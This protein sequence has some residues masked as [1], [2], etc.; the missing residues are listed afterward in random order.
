[1]ANMR[2]MELL[3]RSVE[4]AALDAALATV[5]A[6]GPAVVLVSGEAGIGKTSLLRA[7]VAEPSDTRLFAG[8][9]DAPV[10]AAAARPAARHRRG[11]GR[12][13]RDRSPPRARR[14]RA[15][16]AA[17]AR[18][19]RTGAAPRPRAR[20][21]ALGRRG[22]PRRRCACSRRRI[23]AV[24]ALVVATYRDD[25]LDR[26][27]PLRIAL[28]E[29]PQAPRTGCA[30]APLRAE[31]VAAL[32]E[33][34]GASIPA[35]STAS[36]GGQ[37]VL[38]H[39]GPRRRRTARAARR[40]SATR[41][42]RAPARLATAPARCS[43]RSRSCR[44]SAEL[45][46][47]EALAGGDL[48]RARRLPRA[49]AC[50]G[51]RGRRSR[52]ATRSRASRWRTRSPRTRGWPC[53]PRRSRRSPLRRRGR[54]D[55]ARLAHHAEAAGD[56]EAVLAYAPAAGEQAAALGAHREAA[57]QFARALRHAEALEPDRRAALLERV[58]YEYYLINC[59]RRGDRGPPGRARRALAAGDRCAQGRC[60]PLAV[61]AGR[62]SRATT[63]RPRSEA[64]HAIDLLEPLAPGP[65]LAMAYSNMAQLRMLASDR[66]GR[67]GLGRARD[68]AGRA[69]RRDGDPR[70]RAQQ[71]R[72][73]GDG[74]RAGEEG[75]R[76][77]SAASC[78]P[79]TRGSRSTSARAY[80][81]LAAH[82][83][84]RATTRARTAILDAG[85]AYCPERDLDSWQAVHERLPGAARV[86]QGR[87]DRRR[88]DRRRVLRTPN[89]R[90]RPDHAAGGPGAHPRA[91]RRARPVVAARRGARARRGDRRAAAARRRRHRAG[92][93]ALAGGR[94][95]PGR[96]PRRPRCSPS[97]SSRQHDAGWSASS[98]VVS[99]RRL[100][101]APRRRRARWPSRG[102]ELDGEYAKAA[103]ALERSSA[104]RTRSA[105][106]PPPRGRRGPLQRGLEELQRLGRA[107]RAGVRR[108]DAARATGSRRAAGP[109]RRD[110]REP[111]RHDRARARGARPGP[112]RGCATPRSPSG[113]FVSEKTVDH[114]VSAILRKLGGQ[115]AQRGSRRGGTGSGSSKDRESSR[116]GRAVAAYRVVSVTTT[117]EE[118]AWTC[119]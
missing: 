12:R 37:P 117:K 85:I 34:D 35:S 103:K 14:R 23:E 36:R 44:T 58:S 77:S 38:R 43:T 40:P 99:A 13:P 79:S 10:H 52:S 55:R 80:T 104:A 56:R 5:R 50:C 88:R 70:P 51:R 45:W 42:W 28:G 100:G 110:P 48:G 57:A 98:R 1:M 101:P 63:R 71:R 64:R 116:C 74:A 91:P 61:A 3:E 102:L 92:R 9:C 26:D 108:P 118:I 86:R 73:R 46:L 62:G 109:A 65:E 84:E 68:R 6:S 75:T 89:G 27:H 113:S 119:T 112:A 93:G 115:D 20:G 8:A 83:V 7:F 60:P 53:T 90:P 81:N 25:E 69:P 107:R 11:G 24:P 30:L 66:H 95:R 111:G 16:V 96:R 72:Q 31:A 105:L 17:L 59:D 18:E 94:V 67:D 39:R 33:P 106:A 29:L 114:H 4:S 2:R 21:P 47:L 97:R 15:V 82:R 32:A 41:C 22:D 76:S 87:W 19:L 78:S 54:P 49:R